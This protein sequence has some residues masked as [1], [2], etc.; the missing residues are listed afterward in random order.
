MDKV[1]DLAILPKA[2]RNTKWASHLDPIIDEAINKAIRPSVVGKETLGQSTKYYENARSAVKI[3]VENKGNLKLTDEFL[4]PLPTESLPTNL[5]EFQQAIDQTKKQIFTEYD[6]LQKAAGEQGATVSLDSLVTELEKISENPSIQDLAPNVANY[7]SKRAEALST[8]G[9][10]SPQEAQDAIAGLNA[11]LDAFYKN[12]SSVDANTA[13]VDAMIVNQLRENL[14]NSITLAGA[15][16]YQPL[17]NKYGAL[18]TIEKDLNHRAVVFARQNVKSFIDFSDIL[19]AGDIVRGIVFQQ[20]E[21]IVKGLIQKG[22]ALYYRHLN[23]PNTLVK[24]M[25]EKVD[26]AMNGVRF[27]EIPNPS[28]GIS[29]PPIPPE[30]PQSNIRSVP[31]RKLLAQRENTPVISKR[32]AME[33][34]L[35]DI[36]K[37]LTFEKEF[38]KQFP[39]LSGLT[40][41]RTGE[42]PEL[43]GKRTSGKF[44]IGP[45]KRG[46]FAKEGDEIAKNLGMDVEDL[47]SGRSSSSP[48][49]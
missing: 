12:P 46:R 18:K 6:T 25:F 5:R 31:E 30:P 27:R 1:R 19:S 20:N 8:R 37:K 33:D 23:N 14:D 45:D 43:G 44:G 28:E 10:Y 15:E 35:A 13:Q 17:K 4:E 34:Q 22:I 29:S 38:L 39:D 47:P 49:R 11:K 24:G 32:K 40:N 2:I 16:R 21:F 41:R 9:H 42:L 36:E 7:A 48:L 26:G 3:I